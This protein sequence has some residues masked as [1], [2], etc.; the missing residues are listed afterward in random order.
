MVMRRCLVFCRQVA[1]RAHAT[2]TICP[3]QPAAV[4]IVA[5][6]ARHAMRVHLTLEERAPLVDLAALLSVGVIQGRLEQ[7]RSIV[8]VERLPGLVPVGDLRATRMA[9]RARLDLAVADSR[10]RPDGVAGREVHAPVDAA[11][12]VEP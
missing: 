2:G 8:I 9:L 5:V 10:P 3:A 7:H 12:L 4:W 6:A 1:G 11:A